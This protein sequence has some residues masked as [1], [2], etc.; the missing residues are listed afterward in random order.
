MDSSLFKELWKHWLF[1]L[2]LLACLGGTD[3]VV[4]PLFQSVA[5]AGVI[6]Y[7]VARLPWR[8]NDSDARCS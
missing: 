8:R 6:V 5:V 2:V 3:F 7:I 4:E 1:F